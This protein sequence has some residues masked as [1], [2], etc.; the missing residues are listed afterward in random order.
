[1]FLVDIWDLLIDP[2][3]LEGVLFVGIGGLGLLLLLLLY[4]ISRDPDES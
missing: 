2:A 1:M 3:F 4:P